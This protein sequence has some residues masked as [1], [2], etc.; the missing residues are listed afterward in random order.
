MSELYSACSF[1]AFFWKPIETAPRET[2][3]LILTSD[4]IFEARLDDR[5]LWEAS[6]PRGGGTYIVGYDPTHW[7]PRPE[8]PKTESM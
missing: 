3:V 8:N 5:G 7:M 2:W 6:D 4:G 1:L